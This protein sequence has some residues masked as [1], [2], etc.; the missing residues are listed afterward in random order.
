MELPH[1]RLEPVPGSPLA[2]PGQPHFQRQ[3]EEEREIGP[4]APGGE[5]RDRADQV[6][7]ETSPIPLVRERGVDVL[8]H[9]I[10]CRKQPERLVALSDLDATAKPLSPQRGQY[11][12]PLARA[13]NREPHRRPPAAGR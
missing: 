10:A 8:D 6:Q 12:R 1:L 4:Q 3:V 13:H 7:I 11:Q 2:H 9:R 5:Q